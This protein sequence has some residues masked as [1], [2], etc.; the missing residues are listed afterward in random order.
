MGSAIY[1]LGKASVALRGCNLTSQQGFGVWAVQRARVE[2]R[3][4]SAI[5]DCG[6]SGVVCFG[7]PTVRLRDS[8]IT[9]AAMH[10]ICARGGSRVSLR[11][12]RI[13]GCGVR[14]IYA[15]HNVSLEMRSTVRDCP[16]RTGAMCVCRLLS[17][18]AACR[19]K[20]FI[21]VCGPSCLVGQVVTGTR[22]QYGAAVQI[23]ALRP[24]DQ[25][26]LRMDAS[27]RIEANHG[28]GLV[29]KGNVREHGVESN[30]EQQA[31]AT[32]SSSGRQQQQPTASSIVSRIGP[33]AQR[34]RRGGVIMGIGGST[35]PRPALT[36]RSRAGWPRLSFDTTR[37]ELPG[38]ALVVTTARQPSAAM[39]D[40]ARDVSARL[41]APLVPRD[42]RSV[43]SVLDASGGAFCYVVARETRADVR[44]P[45]RHELARRADGRR[46]FVNPRMWRLATASGFRAT[47]LAR[48]LAPPG[49]PAPTHVI[50]ATAGLG[51]TALRISEAF[52]CAVTA[53]EVSAPLACL[54]DHGMRS[55]AQQPKPWAKA[56]QRVAVVHADAEDYLE[57][58]ASAKQGPG[59]PC[60]V[61]VNPC[62]DVRRMDDEDAFLQQLARL[63]PISDSCLEHA[64]A[65]ATQRVVLR[66]PKAADTR[67]V[68]R[69]V[70]PPADCVKGRQSDYWVFECER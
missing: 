18:C 42:D 20:C 14:G 47:P 40:E 5:Q 22:D 44:T 34:G 15:Y 4:G 66:L 46:L 48:A 51:G 55:L 62:L 27:C 30:Q 54:L 38:S 61:F 19:R 43:A 60:A 10:G 57:R 37:L 32:V 3:N 52:G 69:A 50:D 63:A 8:A 23:E 17:A 13:A 16:H 7:Q 58:V 31:A 2:L 56:A 12:T 53:V 49:A 11:G 9:D 70:G 35:P 21:K 25:C 36:A 68:I 28:A 29:V 1:A 33:V 6:R 39:L 26:E 65:A 64:L 59:R 24:C 41:G 67:S 45:I